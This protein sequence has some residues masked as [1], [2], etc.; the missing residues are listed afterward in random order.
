MGPNALPVPVVPQ[1]KC[2]LFVNQALFC[3][4]AFRLFSFSGGKEHAVKIR[5]NDPYGSPFELIIPYGE[6]EALKEI[7]EYC[8]A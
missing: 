1:D 7:I 6:P 5:Y 2:A 8:R 3:G 4:D